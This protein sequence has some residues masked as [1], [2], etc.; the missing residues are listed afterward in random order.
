MQR[1]YSSSKTVRENRF[2]KKQSLY[3]FILCA[4][5]YVVPFII[6]VVLIIITKGRR[7]EL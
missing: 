4:M 1:R 7:A 6:D 3:V 2:T 5:T